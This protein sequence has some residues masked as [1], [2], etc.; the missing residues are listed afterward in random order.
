LQIAFGYIVGRIAVIVF[1]LPGY[2]RGEMLSAYQILEQRFGVVTRRL[3]SLVFLVTRN[4]ADGLRLFLTAMALNIALGLPMVMCILVTSIAT[5]IYSCAGGVRS[6]VWND[7]IQFF[8]YIL[9]AI[10]AAF[11]LLSQIP[12]GWNE[13]V[14]FGTVTGRWQLFDFDLSLTKPT[15]TFWCGVIGGGFLSLASHGVDQLIVQRYLCAKSRSA[16]AWALGLS[17]FIVLAQ[18]ALFLFI[19]VALACFDAATGGIGS[20]VTGDTAFMT[21]V[22]KHMGIGLKGLIL[23]AILSAAMSTVAS[24]LNSSASS[25]MSDWIEPLAPP[26]SDRTSLRLSRWLTIGFAIVQGGVAIAAYELAMKMAIIDAVLIIAG[27]AIGLLLGL[28]GLG[29]IAPRTTE[30]IALAAFA[31]GL[32]VMLFVWLGTP[33]GGYWYTL[34][35]SSSIVLVGLLLGGITNRSKSVAPLT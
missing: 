16:A 29:L 33:L 14:S 1:L 13:L 20:E 10:A 23:A 27:F 6:V 28:Y 30:P 4:L 15:M 11:L 2:F 5:A 22:V 31:V 26:L 18:F 24:S 8:V 34:V 25:L 21:Y 7:C 12:G 9:G 17:G 19:G 3:A 32:V 35:G